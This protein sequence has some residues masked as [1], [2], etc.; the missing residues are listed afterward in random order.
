[1]RCLYITS[2]RL[3]PP[4]FCSFLPVCRITSSSLPSKPSVIYPVT[5]S[6]NPGT[7]HLL[8]T[9]IHCL[10]FPHLVPGELTS[11][12]CWTLVLLLA[13]SVWLWPIQDSYKDSLVFPPTFL[14]PEMLLMTVAA[15]LASKLLASG[16]SFLTQSFNKPFLCDKMIQLPD[17]A[18]EWVAWVFSC[19]PNLY[20]HFSELSSHEK[21]KQINKPFWFI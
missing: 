17:A 1:M 20:P 8:P 16:S 7:H 18:E 13:A 12:D 2:L 4:G 15:S 6:V 14:I 21:P 11:V 19:F 9:Q 5:Y 10:P 3:R